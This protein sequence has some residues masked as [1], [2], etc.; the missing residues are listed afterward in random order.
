MTRKQ[1]NVGVACPTEKITK[2]SG[3]SRATLLADVIKAAL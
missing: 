3:G 2:L 1:Q